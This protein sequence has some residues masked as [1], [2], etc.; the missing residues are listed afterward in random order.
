MFRQSDDPGFREVLDKIR[1][2]TEFT[3]E[4]EAEYLV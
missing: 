4:K 2:L 1:Q 3:L